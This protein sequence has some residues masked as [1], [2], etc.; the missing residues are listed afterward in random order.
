MLHSFHSSPAVGSVAFNEKT[1]V[2]LM[3]VEEDRVISE[4]DYARGLSGEFV[5]QMSE[6]AVKTETSGWAL[7]ETEPIRYSL[8][9][10]VFQTE[11]IVS[12]EKVTLGTVHLQR[13]NSESG[14]VCTNLVLLDLDKLFFQNRLIG[15]K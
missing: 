12:V 3:E 10:L 14:E 7:V 15:G 4:L 5:W 8:E 11:K 13:E 9:D 6:D 2:G 1:F